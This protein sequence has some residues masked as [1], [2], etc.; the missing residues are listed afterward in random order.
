MRIYNIIALGGNYMKEQWKEIEGYDGRYLISNT[1]KVY[2]KFSK[3]LLIG[4]STRGYKFYT[5][6]KNGVCKSPKAHR[7]VA[8]H[9]LENTEN[10]PC[11]N[12]IDGDPSNN[13][14]SNLEWCTYSE[15]IIHSFKLGL[16]KPLIGKDNP[17]HGK[18]GSENAKSKEVVMIDI[19]TMK[20]LKQFESIELAVDFLKNQGKTKANSSSISQ[21]CNG[22]RYKTAY[23]YIWRFKNE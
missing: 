8:I 15:N 18:R 1:G 5:L 4:N 13:N 3:R 23:G 21:C 16:Q 12:H 9:F 22:V 10:K 7:L 19:S 11:V 14:V 20:I 2:S 17:M 6:S